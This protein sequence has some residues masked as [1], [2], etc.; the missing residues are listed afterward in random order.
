MAFN[1]EQKVL[2][3]HCDPAGIVFY[4][5]YFEMINDTVEWFFSDCLKMPFEHI[6]LDGSG[7]P[8][9]EINTRFHAPS[10]HGDMLQIALTPLNI[11]NTSMGLEVNATCQ[12][13]LRFSCDLI[14]VNVN[15]HGKPNPWEGSVRDIVTSMMTMNEKELS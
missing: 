9:V 8:T 6:H 4:P 12:N 10:R 13:E 15:K 7:V 2:F 1:R 5:R 3:K 14:L 11:G